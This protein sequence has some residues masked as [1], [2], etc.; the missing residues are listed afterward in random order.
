VPGDKVSFLV[1]DAYALSSGLGR[2]DAAFAGFWFSH[3][4]KARRQ[5]FLRGLGALLVPGARVVL[6]DNLYVEGSNSPITETDAAAN[7]YQ[8]RNLED[9]SVHRV[10]KNFPSQAELQTSLGVLGTASKLRTW[11]HYWAFEYVAAEPAQA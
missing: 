3:V 6:L 7:T 8:S 11:Q 4:P 5:E 9:G 10:L 2:F 1:G